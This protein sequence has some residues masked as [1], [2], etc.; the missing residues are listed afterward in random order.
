MKSIIS[1]FN[2]EFKKIKNGKFCK[3]SLL[4]LA[5]K[6]KTLLLKEYDH[7]TDF[8]DLLVTY[9]NNIEYLLE[10]PDKFEEYWREFPAFLKSFDFN[11]FVGTFKE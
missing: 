4:S 3:E 8:I 9:E 5:K 10:L 2:K 6:N 7:H 1:E 11:G